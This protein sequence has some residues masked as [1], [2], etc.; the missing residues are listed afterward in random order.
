MENLNFILEQINGSTSILTFF[1][2]CWAACYLLAFFEYR[3][4]HSIG[5]AFVGLPPAISLML[6]MTS[7]K[8]GELTTRFTVW[9][10]RF[11]TG[12]VLPFSDVQTVFLTLGVTG[13][14]ISVLLL[15]RILSRPY[16]GEWPWMGAGLIAGGYVVISTL[17]HIFG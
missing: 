13:T 7:E 2:L 8:V 5:S 16:L 1:F 6:I 14:A 3:G 4:S 15:I 17:F 9:T 12:G 10:W 11:T